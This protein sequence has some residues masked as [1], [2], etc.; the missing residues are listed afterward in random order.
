MNCY[1]AFTSEVWKIDLLMTDQFLKYSKHTDLLRLEALEKIE[2]QGI[3]RIFIDEI[4]RVPEL[5][6]EVHFLIEKT[7]C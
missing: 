7:G 2:K 1:D 6:N 4:Q 3:K 5:L